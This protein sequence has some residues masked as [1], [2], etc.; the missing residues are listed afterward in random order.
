[1]N[2]P[3]NSHKKIEE[4]PVS[5]LTNSVYAVPGTLEDWAYAGS[6]EP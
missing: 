3:G 6:W 2:A 5:T 4:Y 1:M